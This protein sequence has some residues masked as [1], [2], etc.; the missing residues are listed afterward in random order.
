MLRFVRGPASPNTANTNDFLYFCAN[1]A[2]Q[3]INFVWGSDSQKPLAWS[4]KPLHSESATELEQ[5]ERQPV[6]TR[7]FSKSQKTFNLASRINPFDGLPSASMGLGVCRVFSG[8]YEDHF[9]VFQ[10][11][12]LQFGLEYHDL[13]MGRLT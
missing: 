12:L 1:G 11:V 2:I 6:T 4:G 13:R 10:A 8:I 9:Q 3:R 5:T 7:E